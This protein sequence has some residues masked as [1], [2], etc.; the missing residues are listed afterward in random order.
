MVGLE[1]KKKICITVSG[2]IDRDNYFI[3]FS[4]MLGIRV[5]MVTC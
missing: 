2:T 4:A 5:I 3:P 1:L